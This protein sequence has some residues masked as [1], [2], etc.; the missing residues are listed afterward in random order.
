MSNSI[1]ERIVDMQFNNSQFESGIKE[2]TS[3]LDKL[4]KGLNLDKSAASLSNLG[5]VAKR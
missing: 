5:D 1:D 4:K 2:S 3:S